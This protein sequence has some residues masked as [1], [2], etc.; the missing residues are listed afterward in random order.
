MDLSVELQFFE[1]GAF[2]ANWMDIHGRCLGLLGMTA[3]PVGVLS[4]LE[5]RDSWRYYFDTTDRLH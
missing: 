1:S 2:T 5:A 3:R 4:G